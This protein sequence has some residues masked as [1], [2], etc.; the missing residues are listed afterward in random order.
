MCEGLTVYWP[1]RE[2]GQASKKRIVPGSLFLY[3]YLVVTHISHTTCGAELAA[4][5]HIETVGQESN[6]P[7]SFRMSRAHYQNLLS[8]QL[9]S[10]GTC[11]NR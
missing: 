3:F 9:L 2:G 1:W 7:K 6:L 5:T 11:W 10:F 8:S 4:M